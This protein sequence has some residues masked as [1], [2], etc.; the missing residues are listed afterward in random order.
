MPSHTHRKYSRYGSSGFFIP[1]LR[2]T[3]LRAFSRIHTFYLV[4]CIGTYCQLLDD[5]FLT[6]DAAKSPYSY[7]EICKHV[8]PRLQRNEMG[9]GRQSQPL[10][11]FLFL[12]KTN[13][14]VPYSSPTDVFLHRGDSF[15]CSGQFFANMIRKTRPS[16]NLSCSLLTPSACCRSPVACH[17]CGQASLYSST[18]P[19][20]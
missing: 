19:V 13:N 4:L 12:C 15:N 7:S 1:S 10:N 11:D 20:A 14:P 9:F 8:V 6:S 5:S 17:G 16:D 2:I 18:P 3:L